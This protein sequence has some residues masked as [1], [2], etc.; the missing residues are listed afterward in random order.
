MAISFLSPFIKI[1]ISTF[2]FIWRLTCFTNSKNKQPINPN[3][4]NFYEIC[5]SL[6]KDKSHSIEAKVFAL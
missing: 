2:A 1:N 4:V 3:K 5:I 6:F